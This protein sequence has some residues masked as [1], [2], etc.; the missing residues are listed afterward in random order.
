MRALGV[1]PRA[2][3]QAAP[4]LG[5][6]LGQPGLGQRGPGQRGPGPDPRFGRRAR[7]DDDEDEDL[8]P[9][10]RL[11]KEIRTSLR[12]RGW[13]L[14]VGV[15][16]LAMIPVGIAVVLLAGA[17]GGSGASDQEQ[18]SLGFPPANFATADFTATA[19]Q[20]GRG[21]DQDLTA[22][23]TS[24]NDVVA[25]GGETGSQVEHTEFFLS[26]NAGR[27]WQLATINGSP[28]PGHTPT[29]VAGG[30]NGW[31]A[32][33]PDSVWTSTNGTT[34]TL[35]ST[36][37]LPQQA[38]DTVNVVTRT[39]NGFLAVGSN[40]NTPVVWTSANGSTWQRTTPDLPDGGPIESAAA[41]ANGI[42]IASKTA[43]WR[44]TNGTDW[45]QVTIP[46]TDAQ[47]T[48]AGVA[49]LGNGFVAIRHGMADSE[50]IA[51]TS[52]NG[53]TWTDSATIRTGNGA[54]LT[55]H[56]VTGGTSGAAITGSADDVLFAFIT[57]NGT[58][59]IG[60]NNIAT[61]AQ[62][63][64]TGAALTGNNVVVTTGAAPIV[65]A[66]RTPQ[67][68]LI[69]EQGDATHITL[70]GTVSHQLAVN[71]LAANGGTQV[72]AGGAD[73]FPA[74]WSSADG[75]TSWQRA[76]GAAFD[77]QGVQQLTGV[78]HGNAGWVTVGSVVSGA[79]A[80]PVVIVSPDATTWTTADNELAFG[81]AGLSATAVGA[82]KA[83]YV[84]GGEQ[85][86]NALAW[87]STGL[88]GWQLEPLPDSAGA[89][90]SAVAASGSTFVAVGTSAGHPIAWI[91]LNDGQWRATT[92]T[93]P[94]GASS[95]ELKVVAVNGNRLVAAGSALVG[96]ATKP[97]AVVSDDDGSSWVDSEIVVQGNGEATVTALT[98]AGSGFTATGTDSSQNV[99]IWTLD[100]GTT[101]TTSIPTGRGLSGDGS[102][103]LNTLTASGNELTGTG[104]VATAGSEEP[105]IWQSPLRG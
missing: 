33:G 60:T 54:A 99:V 101:W 51:Y 70:N 102:Q 86:G 48:I 20:V 7:E 46:A 24:G 83:G 75:G 9:Q 82:G 21:L 96:G 42:V 98:A 65:N 3:S 85:N 103:E 43:A 61:T 50:A 12:L 27:T 13:A 55:L 5:P 40:G 37:G 49:Q 32:V 31:V 74:I 22:T 94:S 87:F 17:N 69:G 104:F 16:I 18:G 14:K 81:G 47:N 28:P 100:T 93:L 79:T 67:L 71:A 11:L 56:Q 80:H 73:G 63:T 52:A 4:G 68:A 58:T 105:T 91:R 2:P 44:S 62:E 29:K 57:A 8:T 53:Q 38:G 35:T 78:A 23:A 64:L 39:A 41:T 66:R 72:A 88:T 45:T 26:Q 77:R 92:I 76:T 6:G 97:F 34:W 25:I 1:P 15:P 90:I 84:I 95:A 59:W 10:Q 36:T 89:T 19:A 30:P